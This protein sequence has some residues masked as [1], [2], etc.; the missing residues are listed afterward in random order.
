MKDYLEDEYNNNI[1]Y[2]FNIKILYII[3]ILY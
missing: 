2:S 1:P 3:N